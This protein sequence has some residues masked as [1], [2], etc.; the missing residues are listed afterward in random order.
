M[1]DTYT[2]Q[3]IRY[4]LYATVPGL[5]FYGTLDSVASDGLSITDSYAL[6]DSS[7]GANHYRGNYI[8]RSG[9]AGDDPVKRA[10]LLTPNVGTLTISGSPY[11]DTTTLGY[12]MIGPLH[13]DELNAC[14]T[15]ALRFVYFE[16]QLPIRG[17][18]PN[19]DME[20][21]VTSWTG[22]N[23]VPT[24]VTT[25]S[26]VFSGSSATQA[27]NSSLGGFLSSDAFTVFPN[28]P[29]YCSAVCSVDVGTAELE[30]YDLTNSA[31]IG[32]AVTS[33]EANFAHLWF[34]GNIPATCRSA[35]V[36]LV[37]AESNANVFWNHAICYRTEQL[38]LPAPDW[39]N[40]PSKFL[41]LREAKYNR[42][43]NAQS[44]GGYDDAQSRYFDDWFQPSMYS[45]DPFKLDANP[46]N[47][48]L[49][50]A[51]PKN[52]LWIHAKRPYFD[53]E[54]LGTEVAITHAPL[55]LLAAYSRLELAKVLSTRYPADLR[56]KDLLS[57][58]NEDV[59]SELTSR[60]EV[61][62]QPI[63]FQYAGRV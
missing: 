20:D 28:E 55:N 48:Q 32:S 8:Y 9:T 26:R 5:G 25:A 14:I 36:R 31:V 15:R 17:L 47:I 4:E 33:V 13:P 49:M 54:P 6:R 16:T 1:V 12:E 3:A 10:L 44:N 22:T 29:F 35:A 7:L 46:Y 52:E 61:P 43:L 21:G 50:R 59:S 45:L 19:G 51:I 58:A 56:W 34:I 62:F 63:R 2:R 38:V 23:C 30:L 39:L 24:S 42:S 11:A 53:I 57:H 37:G 18:V 60:P 40:E 27:A 41:K